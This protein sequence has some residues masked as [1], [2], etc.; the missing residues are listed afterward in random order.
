MPRKKSSKS[1]KPSINQKIV[2]LEQQNQQLL[3]LVEKHQYEIR[4]LTIKLEL[5][6]EMLTAFINR[7]TL[8]E[9][10]VGLLFSRTSLGTHS[11]SGSHSD[12]VSSQTQAQLSPAFSL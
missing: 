11:A 5:Q 1:S 2:F 6:Q 10:Q 3:N 7:N 9:Y 12:F 4:M 8:L